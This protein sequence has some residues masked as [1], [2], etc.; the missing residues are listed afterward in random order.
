MLELEEYGGLSL[1][2]HAGAP[3]FDS[4]TGADFD[5]LTVTPLRENQPIAAAAT[6][7]DIDQS[8][9]LRSYSFTKPIE[10]DD[11]DIDTLHAVATSDNPTA[12]LRKAQVTNLL[13]SHSRSKTMANPLGES[14][15]FRS[16]QPSSASTSLLPPNTET[17]GTQ[18][19]SLNGTSASTGL[20]TVGPRN[21]LSGSLLDPS[22]IAAR[23]GGRMS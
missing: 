13:R 8:S 20:D 1:G 7:A 22:S 17:L 18:L 12:I 16:T 11:L 23:S 2:S 10:D 21:F 9:R 4:T 19:V 3:K 5:A 6:L 15:P 14:Q